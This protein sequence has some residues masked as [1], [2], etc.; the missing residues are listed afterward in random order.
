[1]V[2]G[3]YN[4]KTDKPKGHTVALQQP[5]PDGLSFIEDSKM[6]SKNLIEFEPVE[7]SDN[8]LAVLE[9]E[10]YRCDIDCVGCINNNRGIC[11]V[12][13]CEK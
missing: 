2:A 9:P 10:E 3:A 4:Q 11:K 8:L 6:T 13:G 1:M 7:V 12:G 5:T